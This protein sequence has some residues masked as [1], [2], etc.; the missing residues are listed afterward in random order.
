VIQTDKILVI[1]NDKLGDFM[2]TWPAFALLK[3]QYPQ[4]KITALVTPY[5]KDMAERCPWIDDIILDSGDNAFLLSKKIKPF[6]FDVCIALYTQTR[7]ALACFLSRIPVRISPATK[8]AQIF[9]NRTLIQ[10]RSRSEKPEFEYNIDLVKHLSN[11][12]GDAPVAVP[13]PPYLKFEPAVITGIRDTYKQKNNIADTALLIIIHP[14]TGGSAINFSVEQYA[15]LVKA[16]AEVLPVFIIITA[17]PGETQTAQSLSALIPDIDHDIFH[18]DKGIVYFSQFIA[19]SDLFI[20]G[21][22]GPLHIAA[23]LNVKTAA[24]YPARKSATALRWQ[25]TNEEHNRIA[26][27]PEKYI[28]ENDMAGI[29]PIDCG[30]KIIQFLQPH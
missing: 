27:S 7:T 13:S 24:F 21:S 6:Q 22:T 8:L 18:S 10:R 17:G 20:S 25:T 12:R 3:K 4:S 29:D 28:D 2:L 15:T 16:V 23:A 11:L 19:C 5:T 30:K 1:R 26:F 14:G 9:S